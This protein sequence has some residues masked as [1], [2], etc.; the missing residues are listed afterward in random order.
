MKHNAI[1]SV[2]ITWVF[3]VCSCNSDFTPRPRA[4]FRIDLPQKKFRTFAEPGYPYTFEYPYYATITREA[5]SSG[6]NPYW[7]NLDFPDFHARIHLSY[8]AVNGTSVY[9]IKSGDRYKD[10]VVRNSFEG[11]R[12]EAYK[13]TYK[14]S[15]RASG[16]VDSLFRNSQGSGGVYF[17]VA[18]EA[19]TS[20]QFFVTDTFRHFMRGALY[21]QS[22]PNADSLSMASDF[23]AADIRHLI[24]T[25]Q[26]K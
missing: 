4:Y 22:S 11:L 18:G 19:A 9:K 16:I 12:E 7:I 24:N 14:H 15:V 13:M 23:L 26:W 20:R 10:S 17:Y 25:L 21:F 8:K 2:I 5:D 3:A 6:Y 1:C